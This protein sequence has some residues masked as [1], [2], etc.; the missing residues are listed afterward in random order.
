MPF[1][2]RFYLSQAGEGAQALALT[3]WRKRE[4]TSSVGG[5]VEEPSLS[6]S[7]DVLWLGIFAEG[8]FAV[9]E[10]RPV[11]CGQVASPLHSRLLQ[12]KLVKHKSMFGM[13]SRESQS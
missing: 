9:C 2:L 7:S 13:Q 10:A 6:V 11:A 1:A 4:G 12:K 8:R 5:C 3:L